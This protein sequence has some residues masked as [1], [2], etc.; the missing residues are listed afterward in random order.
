MAWFPWLAKTAPRDDGLNLER[1]TTA[2]R[3]ENTRSRIAYA[4][5]VLLF[6]I[7]C[8]GYGALYIVHQQVQVEAEVLMKSARSV[9]E[10]NRITAALKAATDETRAHGELLSNYLNIVFGP[11]IALLGSVIGFYF[12]A[13]SLKSTQGQPPGSPSDDGGGHPKYLGEPTLDSGPR[14]VSAS[15]AAPSLATEP[16]STP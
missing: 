11:V 4:L 14:L 9:D 8:A 5:L 3:M 13:Q 7:I 16:A 1:D 12:G 10:V 2:K 15:M 6:V